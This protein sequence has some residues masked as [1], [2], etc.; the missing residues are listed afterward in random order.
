MPAAPRPSI[1]RSALALPLCLLACLACSETTTSVDLVLTTNPDLC[2]TAEVLAEVTT[3]VVVVDAPGGLHGVTAAGPLA[4]GGT[5]V[6]F[7]GDGELEVV[8]TAPPLDGSALPILEVGLKHNADRELAYRVLGYPTGVA[9]E[10][11]NAV[12][13]GGVTAAC[14]V[15]ETRSVGTPFNLRAVARPPKVILVLPPDDA[16]N[17]PPNLTA[18]TVMFSTTVQPESLDGA[19][20]LVGPD[21]VDRAIT[22]SA[23]TLT[24]AGEGGVDEK[25]SLVTIA[26][27]D[28]IM[29]VGPGAEQYAVIVGAG[30]TST[31]GRAFDQDPTTPAVDGF[32]SHFTVGSG[33]GGGGHPCD[34]CCDT[35]VPAYLCNDTETGCVPALDC[36]AGCGS[37]FVCAPAGGAC[38]ED[39]RLYGAC[40]APGATCD[41]AT[42]LCG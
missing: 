19:V 37:G 12:A 15:G 39:C 30:I 34:A 6:D 31:T 7:D 8:F 18:I 41:L 17:V 1:R 20:R 29:P 28:P 24:Y 38:V 11:A 16:Q 23:D 35:C 13:L 22:L 33:V 2:S 3:V 36:Q 5:A 4:G 10:P 26:P 40:A 9:L 27:V 14:A 42:G 32:S 25:R 21:G